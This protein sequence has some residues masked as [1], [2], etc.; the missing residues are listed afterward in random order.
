MR[1]N[2]IAFLVPDYDPAIA[3]FR[4][5]DFSLVT[6]E[7]RGGGKRWVVMRPSD[8][9]SD[10]LIARAVD[11][12][13]AAIGQQAGGRVGFFLTSTDFA[14]DAARLEAAGAVFEEAPRHEEYGIVAVFRDPWGNRWD[15]IQPAQA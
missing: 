8:G 6:D 1:L 4:A 12:Q 3:F 2:L 13:R 14:A 10:L 5:L 9:G 7:D 15:L 11:D